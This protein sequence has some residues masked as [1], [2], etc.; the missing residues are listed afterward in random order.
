MPHGGLIKVEG[1]RILAVRQGVDVAAWGFFKPV[2][3]ALIA[4]DVVP[5]P[6]KPLVERGGLR[7]GRKAQNMVS[8]LAIRANISIDFAKLIPTHELPRFPV[9][10]QIKGCGCRPC[11]GRERIALP[12]R[13][14]PRS[15]WLAMGKGRLRLE[16]IRSAYLKRKCTLIDQQNLTR[17]GARPPVPLPVPRLLRALV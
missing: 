1:P 14:S 3:P 5:P 17:A 2:P 13:L 4:E 11:N 6:E 9:P 15:A 7:F 12:A 8:L 16:L 10:V